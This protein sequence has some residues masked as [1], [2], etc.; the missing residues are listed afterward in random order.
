MALVLAAAALAWWW[1]VQRMSGMGASLARCRA[2][3]VGECRRRPAL[4]AGARSGAW[5]I[6]CSWALMAALFA[7]GVMSVTW[8]IVIAVLVA[9]EKTGPWPRAT[10]VATAAVLVVLAVGILAAPD[11][12]PGLVMPAS[13]SMHAMDMSMSSH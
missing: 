13:G 2:H 9:L 11:H 10:R 8:M 6:G 1:T 4:I 12:M 5:C 3:L 7:L